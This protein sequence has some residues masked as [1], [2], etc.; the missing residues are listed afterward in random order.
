M[1][2]GWGG[3]VVGPFYLVAVAPYSVLHL[4]VCIYIDSVII[5]AC[6]F[7]SSYYNK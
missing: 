5:A 1:G 6:V 7:S 4:P 3:D 2:G